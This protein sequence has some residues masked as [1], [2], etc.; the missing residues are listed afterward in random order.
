MGI[1][2]LLCLV[3]TVSMFANNDVQ[4]LAPE[5]SSNGGVDTSAF[6][7]ICNSMGPNRVINN[8][9]GYT[10]VQS[11]IYRAAYTTMS[12]LYLVK[13]KFMMTPGYA[14]DASGLS[15]YESG[16]RLGKGHVSVL[17]KK[18]EDATL[19][20]YGGDIVVKSF[21]PQ[22]SS[23]TSTISS[24]FGCSFSP[25]FS[26]QK[27]IGAQIGDGAT[28]SVEEGYGSSTSLS[29][30]WSVSS[31]SVVADPMVSAQYLSSSNMGVSWNYEVINED[32]AG[33]LT[34]NL[35]TYVLF[36]K[37]IG[38]VNCGGDAFREVFHVSTIDRYLDWKV[39]PFSKD[40]FYGTEYTY[41]HTLNCFL[42]IS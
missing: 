40:W 14:A 23:V 7:Q 19:N 29:F 17:I 20:Q 36:E 32:I 28:L 22:S 4:R 18:Y 5:S 34:Y 9:D 24:S 15:N 37:K 41:D 25:S 33:K 31:S 11:D 42:A 1:L 30:S 21:W 10:Y 3:T 13:N 8:R 26:I 39:W 2:N 35:S 38:S 27:T 16:A 12:D 6:R